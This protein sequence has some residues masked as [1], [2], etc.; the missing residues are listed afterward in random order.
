MQK[1]KTPSPD[2][3]E[4]VKKRNR[5]ESHRRILQA[6]LETF[7]ELGYDAVTTKMIAARA[8]LNESLLHRYF[9]G[10]AGLLFEVHKI[11]LEAMKN[12]KPYPSQRTPEEEICRF[13]ES[14]VEFDGKNRDFIRVIVSRA[15]VD[16]QFREEITAQM[17]L[18]LDSFFRERLKAFQQKGMIKRSVDTDELFHLVLS[19]SFSIGVMERIVFNK[20]AERCKKQFRIFAR[21]ISEGISPHPASFDNK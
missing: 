1:K 15:L 17:D 19:M 3:A 5:L 8:G 21:V 11:S 20:S 13:M 18:E 16:R 9:E 6:G 10:K 7:S 14:K 4:P 2:P 12:Q